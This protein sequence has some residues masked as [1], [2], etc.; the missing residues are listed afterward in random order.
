MANVTVHDTE[1]KGKGD[2]GADCQS[3]A[4]QQPIYICKP[5]GQVERVLHNFVPLPRQ[6]GNCEE[7]GIR[8]LVSWEAI[9]IDQHLA[10]HQ[11]LKLVFTCVH[12]LSLGA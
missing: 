7:G 11:A 8:F 6:S 10:K 3:P 2:L 4:S 1:Q 5:L 9:G 12:M